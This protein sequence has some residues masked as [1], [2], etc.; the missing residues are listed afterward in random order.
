[1]RAS[2]PSVPAALAVRWAREHY[3]IDA[4]A[5]ALPGEIDANFLL[6][7]ETGP[8]AVLKVAPASADR[9]ELEAQVAVLRHLE[10]SPIAGLVPALCAAGDGRDLI[11]VEDDGGRELVLRVVSYLEGT[12]LARAELDR[13]GLEHALGRFL[14]QLDEAL[15]SFDHP[16]AHRP[17]VWDL[18]RLEELAGLVEYLRPELRVP[19]EAGLERFSRAVV[20]HL[21]ELPRGVIHNDANDHN[22]LVAAGDDGVARLTGLID[23]GDMVHTILVAEPAIACAYAML[24]RDDPDAVAAAVVSGYDEVRPLTEVERRLLP[25]LVVGRLCAS[26]LLAAEGRMRAP[27]DAYLTIS[28]RPVA[29]L[30]ERLVSST[31]PRSVAIGAERV[32]ERSRDEILSIRRAHLGRN[33]SVAY[34]QPLKIVR[35]EG[36]YLFDADGRRFLDLVNNVAHVG[37]CHPRVVEAGQRQMARLNTNSRY[38]HDG[39]AEYVIR[40]TAR[41]PEP[42]SVCFL[43][44]SGSEAVELALRLARTHTGSASDLLVLDSCLPRQHPDPGRSADLAVQVPTVLAA[45]ALAP[46][47]HQVLP[48]PG[49]LPRSSHRADSGDSGE[50]GALLCR[51]RR[52][53]HGWTR[54]QP[55]ETQCRPPSSPSR[56]LG[57]GGQ[58][59]PPRRLPVALR[60]KQVRAAGGCLH[61]RRGAGRFRPGSALTS[62]ASRLGGVVPDIVTLGKPIG[63]GHPLGAVVTTPEIAAS[64]D[65]GMEYFNTF[66]GNPVSCAVGRGGPRRDSRT[67]ELQERAATQLAPAASGNGLQRLARGRH[68]RDRRRPRAPGSSS[69]WSWSAIARPPRTR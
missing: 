30:L 45:R 31:G 64:F 9:A 14:G 12:P 36:P 69:A 11:E 49:S 32:P 21:D 61:R 67:R 13:T 22:L 53:S 63:N 25:D 7:S 46:H 37:H 16:G 44:C 10:G 54:S 58:I 33:L 40:L 52:P 26:L 17:L 4:T 43:V 66:G 3:G 8:A 27:D 2:K 18:A 55:R 41:F 19:V 20:P 34:R 24:D 35:G 1:M 29:A 48:L 60:T 50:T 6:R 62:G 5:S 23:F 59:V 47:V 57:C 39:L 51:A 28:E 65:T 38:L 56:C 68:N 42:L 15:V